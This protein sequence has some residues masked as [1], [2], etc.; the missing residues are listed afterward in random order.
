[1][2]DDDAMNI[3]VISE[4]LASLGFKSTVVNGGKECLKILKNKTNLRCCNYQTLFIDFNMPVMS[5]L[6]VIK[7]IKSQK[8]K[9]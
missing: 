8:K 1:M 9:Y 2:C 4:M 6:E 7:K 3:W 5:G